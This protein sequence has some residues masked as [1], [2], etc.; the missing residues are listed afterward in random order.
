[1]IILKFMMPNENKKTPVTCVPRPLQELQG[2]F[3][4]VRL[5]LTVSLCV[6][7]FVCLFGSNYVF[8][9]L[10]LSVCLSLTES[11]C[12]YLCLSVSVCACLCLSLFCPYRTPFSYLSGS[13]VGFQRGLSDPISL[14]C[15]QAP[16]YYH[17]S[18]A[19]AHKMYLIS[20]FIM[21][22]SLLSQHTA[23][24]SFEDLVHCLYS[25]LTR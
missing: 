4:C 15:V 1:M 3:L 19:G 22:K 7:L 6:P 13:Q 20:C 14:S 21:Y 12:E 2:V 17:Q 16:T 18:Q 10:S 23:R 9:W 24:I 5:W 25:C 8:L 11:F